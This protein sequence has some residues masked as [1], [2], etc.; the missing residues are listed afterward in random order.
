MFPTLLN[1]WFFYFAVTVPVVV[2][3]LRALAPDEQPI[4]PHPCVATVQSPL[5]SEQSFGE[6]FWCIMDATTQPSSLCAEVYTGQSDRIP[7]ECEIISWRDVR[8]GSL[9]SSSRGL[10]TFNLDATLVKC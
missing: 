8:F 7:I 9:L 10:L 2:L 3:T 1:H 6:F 5:T 4:S